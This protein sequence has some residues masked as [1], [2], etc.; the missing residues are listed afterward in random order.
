MALKS[1]KNHASVL[2]RVNFTG[3]GKLLL[4]GIYGPDANPFIWLAARIGT[5]DAIYNARRSGA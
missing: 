1:Y 3:L 4:G 5:A 2:H